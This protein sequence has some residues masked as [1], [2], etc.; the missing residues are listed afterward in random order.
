MYIYIWCVYIYI[1]IYIY[2]CV[3]LHC[4]R[5]LGG[6][7]KVSRKPPQLSRR[8]R[9]NS[10]AEGLRTMS[11]KNDPGRSS[12]A[13]K[14]TCLKPTSDRL[15]DFN[16]HIYTVRR[17]SMLTLMWRHVIHAQVSMHCMHYTLA[18][19]RRCAQKQ[20]ALI[21]FL[22][23]GLLREG[24]PPGCHLTVR[25][26]RFSV[27]GLPVLIQVQTTCCI[28]FAMVLQIRGSVLGTC[29]FSNSL[30]TYSSSVFCRTYSTA[31][32]CLTTSPISFKPLRLPSNCCMSVFMVCRQLNLRTNIHVC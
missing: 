29:C 6:S 16:A 27:K 1:Y 23:F 14:T 2:V 31:L 3:A 17:T 12:Q 22:N 10:S 13:G 26:H 15:Y 4:G 8:S 21:K 18:P 7:G 9:G 11:Q 32:R 5:F 24:L 20:V 30:Q 25:T 19:G 28:V